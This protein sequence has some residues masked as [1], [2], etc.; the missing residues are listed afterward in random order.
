MSVVFYFVCMVLSILATLALCGRYNLGGTT[1][2]TLLNILLPGMGL[3]YVL[4]VLHVVIPREI[5]KATG[6]PPPPSPLTPYIEGYI[7]PVFRQILGM[8]KKLF[9]GDNKPTLK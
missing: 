6:Q 8:L 3:L 5:S 2:L 7:T 9:E 4:Y 1:R